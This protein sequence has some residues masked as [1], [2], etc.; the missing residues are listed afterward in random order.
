M[1]ERVI[2][3]G[4]PFVHESLVL[5]AGFFTYM[6]KYN[7]VLAHDSDIGN[8]IRK[9]ESD[10]ISG[11]TH[12]SKY[13]DTS[14]YED[15]NRVYAYLESKHTSGDTDSQG[16][17]KPFFNI[18]LAARNIWYKATDIDRSSI[19]IRSTKSSD[20]IGALLATV[21]L[22]DWMRRENFGQFLNNWGLNLAGFNETIVKIV[23]KDGKLIPS[24]VPWNRVICDQ[25]DFENNPKIEVLEFTEAQLRQN[26]SYDQDLVDKLCSATRS[27]ETVAGESKDTKSSY[28][29]VYEVHGNLPLSFLTDREEDEKTYVQQMHVV[30]FLAGKEKGSFEDFTLYSGRETQDPYILTSLIPEID[31]SIALRGAVKILFDAQW[32]QNHTTKQIK[33]HLD[34]SS[35]LLFQTSDATF[36]GRNVLRDIQTGDILTHKVNEPLTQ[37]NNQSHDIA[38]MQSYAA[39]WKQ[40]SNELAG[41][42]ESLLG[43]NPPSG[44]AWRQTEALLR[45]SHSL[46]ELMTE[47]KGLALEKMLREFIIPY[48]KKQMD[49]SKEVS[50]TLEANDIQKIDSRYIKNMAIRKSNEFLKEK[51]LNGETVTTDEQDQLTQNFA[52]QVQDGLS[53]QGNQRF[54]KPSEI[55]DKK[56]KEIFKN[57]E[58][59][60]AID[61]TNEDLDREMITTLN[62]LL[63]FIQ[64]KQGQPLNPQEQFIVNKI[65]RL[66][67][68]VSTLELSSIPASPTPNNIPAQP[69]EGLAPQGGSIKQPNFSSPQ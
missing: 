47:N 36:T 1:S 11:T 10:F 22:H 12:S 29:K 49:T 16:R 61:V 50:D 42:S 60:V 34:L 24:V 59:D 13:V 14:L 48:L 41:I 5:M 67:G 4:F 55:G 54:F 32:M 66:T 25:I 44:T 52:Q 23:E 27:R 30:S 68:A 18:V 33:D 58:W 7:S 43:Q 62:A 2:V 9:L 6:P 56:W 65:L 15:I 63:V 57:L 39:Q 51:I 17:E 53:Q 40:A 64:N 21:H 38:Q 31:G 46:F 69:Q 3:E 26:E 19:K 35:K 20:D 8:L 28:I 45:E 37:L